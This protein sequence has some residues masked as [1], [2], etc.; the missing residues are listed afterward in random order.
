L[1]ASAVRVK[2]TVAQYAFVRDLLDV[3]VV[4]RDASVRDYT[5][6]FA[7]AEKARE[8]LKRSYALPMGTTRRYVTGEA[9]SRKL[10]VAIEAVEA[11]V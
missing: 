5:V 8:F 6:T 3:A 2:L 10:R 4:M 11:M 7:D 9:V 1:S